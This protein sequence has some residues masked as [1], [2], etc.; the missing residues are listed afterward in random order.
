[1]KLGKIAQFCRFQGS[2]DKQSL[3]IRLDTLARSYRQD[4][5]FLYYCFDAFWV[6]S[7]WFL[8]WAFSPLHWSLCS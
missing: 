5:P 8:I 4:F 3:K 7:T 6:P 1:M 2:R